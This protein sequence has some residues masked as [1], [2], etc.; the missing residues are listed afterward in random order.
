MENSEKTQR[1]DTPFVYRLS[2]QGSPVQ[3]KVEVGKKASTE[4][5]RDLGW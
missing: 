3:R 2:Y 1:A 5:P 4:I